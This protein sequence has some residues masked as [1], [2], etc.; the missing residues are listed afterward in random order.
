MDCSTESSWLPRA[1][2]S[3][4]EVFDFVIFPV[5][6]TSLAS[7]YALSSEK[8][9]C[10]VCSGWSYPRW[11]V[12]KMLLGYSR[13]NLW[14]PQIQNLVGQL[15]CLGKLMILSF[16]S[17]FS[18]IEASTASWVLAFSLCGLR[19]RKDQG[20]HGCA[21]NPRTSACSDEHYCLMSSCLQI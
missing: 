21:V 7:S 15:C 16:F 13:W 18:Y 3:G 20:V 1:A 9:T 12:S 11:S 6:A 2:W 19:P 5:P 17:R 4:C 8:L 10:R 14:Y